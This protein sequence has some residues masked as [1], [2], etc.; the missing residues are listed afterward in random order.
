MGKTTEGACRICGRCGKLTREHVPPKGAFNKDTFKIQGINEHKR[1]DDVLVW[2]EKVKHGGNARYV[3]CQQCNNLTGDW[4]AR[5]YN[6]F[7]AKIQPYARPR[8]VGIGELDVADFYP[9]RVVKQAL[10]SFLALIDPNENAE[11]DPACAPSAKK[12]GDLP[13]FELFKDVSVAYKS[14]PAIRKFVLDR[15]ARSLPDA[16]GLYMYLIAQPAGR[17][18]SIGVIASRTTGRVAIVSEFAWWPV[19]WVLFFEGEPWEPLLSV[20]DWAKFEY[21]SSVSATLRLPCYWIEGKF[22]LDFRDPKKHEQ[23]VA[24]Q[25]AVIDVRREQRK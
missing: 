25:Q 11:L 7:V 13:P 8:N 16:M 22:P 23:D 20:T 21:Q 24:R 2:Y 15:E 14:L 9:L 4:Y 17:T 12:D 3:T 18:S 5:D 6:N 19:G 1:V 10:C